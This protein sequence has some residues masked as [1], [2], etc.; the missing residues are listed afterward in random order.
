MNAKTAEKIERYKYSLLKNEIAPLVILV[1]TSRR[2]A[3]ITSASSPRSVPTFSYSDLFLSALRAS[4]IAGVSI[5]IYLIKRALTTPQ[6]IPKVAL[7][8][9]KKWEALA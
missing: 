8:I 6:K 4:R 3:L 7:P 5:L 2:A 9:M 1:P